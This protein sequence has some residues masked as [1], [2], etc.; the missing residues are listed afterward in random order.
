MLIFSIFSVLSS[1]GGS[2]FFP[3]EYKGRR[4]TD[5]TTYGS[6]DGR[7]WCG[8]KEHSTEND[9][10]YCQ[11]SMYIIF[12]FKN[13]KHTQVCQYPKQIREN[14]TLPFLL[15]AVSTDGSP[16]IVWQIRGL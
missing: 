11:T 7:L 4:Y 5:C 3:F 1:L 6:V 14:E 12:S 15:V 13:I 2:C 16:S 9:W 8:E 10:G